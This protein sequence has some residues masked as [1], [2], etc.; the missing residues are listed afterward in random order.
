MELQTMDE[1]SFRVDRATEAEEQ[2][3]AA[4]CSGC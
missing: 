4:N 1:S 2:A 3:S